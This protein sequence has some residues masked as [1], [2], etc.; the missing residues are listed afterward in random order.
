MS[1]GIA[2]K[3]VARATGDGTNEIDRRVMLTAEAVSGK[4]MSIKVCITVV[5]GT[6]AISITR[7]D[8]LAISHTITDAE[9]NVVDGNNLELNKWYT[10]T[11]TTDGS[12]TYQIRPFQG[13]PK[14]NSSGDACGA[15]GTFYVK[16]ITLS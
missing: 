14:T 11:W 13:G 3:A 12:P 2:Y 10:V 16:D 9:G 8:S 4:T 1:D 15:T 5:D 6:P 7:G